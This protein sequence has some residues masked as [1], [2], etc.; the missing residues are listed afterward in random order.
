M[1]VAVSGLVRAR[2][3]LPLAMGL[4]KAIQLGC[5]HRPSKDLR[6]ATTSDSLLIMSW[7]LC[8][9]FETLINLLGICPGLSI[10][11]SATIAFHHL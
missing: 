10:T 6:R 9:L 4:D 7:S 8:G 3:Q 5:Q 11:D 2:Q 1:V